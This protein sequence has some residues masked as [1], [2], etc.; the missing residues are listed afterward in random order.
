MTSTK[1]NIT[2]H[3]CLYK[4]SYACILTSLNYDINGY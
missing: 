3:L 1:S 4:K 2:L